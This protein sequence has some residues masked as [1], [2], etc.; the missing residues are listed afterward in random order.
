[1]YLII[2]LLAYFGVF[3]NWDPKLRPEAS[4]CLIS[5]AHGTPAVILASLA[6]KTQLSNRGFASPNS[7]FQNMV[8]EYSIAYFL[9]DLVHYL[10]FFPSDVLFIGHHLATL[11]VFA[12]CRY[13]VIHGAFAI[14]VLLVLAEV[15][16]FCQNTWT[17]ASARKGDLGSASRLYQVLSPPFYVFYSIVRGFAGPLFVYEMGAFY[18]SGAADNVIPRWLWVSWMIV[19]VTAIGVSIMWI[20]NLWVELFR[21]RNEKVEE[22]LQ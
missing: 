15:T 18:L 5:F 11:F 21:D 20:A 6:V 9:M 17:L 4:S 3:R 2:Y 1:M 22:K 7:N 12:T 8:L 10:I 14:L 19:V 13:L 16:S